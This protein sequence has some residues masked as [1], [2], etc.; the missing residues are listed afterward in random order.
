M[1]HNMSILVDRE[2]C[3]LAAICSGI[4]CSAEL[5]SLQKQHGYR[6]RRNV[7]AH[8]LNKSAGAYTD[9]QP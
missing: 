3:D 2:V 5:K 8:R 6:N 9:T 1:R 7:Y 4:G